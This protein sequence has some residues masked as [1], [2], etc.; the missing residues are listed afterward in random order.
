ML[1]NKLE[2]SETTIEQSFI[3]GNVSSH[4]KQRNKNLKDFC[5]N[6]QLLVV[7]QLVERSLLTTAIG[8]SIPVI[9]NFIYFNCIIN[10]VE[11]RK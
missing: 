5:T 10:S 1:L 3:E 8:S 11:R 4:L 9:G 7:V 2:T 6:Y